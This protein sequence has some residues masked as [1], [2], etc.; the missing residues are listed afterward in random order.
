MTMIACLAHIRRKFYDARPQNYSSKSVP[1]KGVT[2][3]NELF[4][5]DK[6][7]KDLSIN[8]RYD[9]RLKLVKTNLEGFFDW[10]ESLT[11]HGKLGVALN[12][13][14]NQKERMM[15]ALKDGRLV[16]S[17]NLA[18]R[19]IKTLVMGAKIS[20]LPFN[21]PSKSTKY[22]TLRTLLII[23]VSDFYL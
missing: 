19:G 15:I 16:L 3:C 12:Y 8:E 9:Q 18:E 7:L 22:Y 20:G 23:G 13:A 5:L 14:L 1:H 4:A 11:A 6:S 2:L 10:C 17:N 21:L